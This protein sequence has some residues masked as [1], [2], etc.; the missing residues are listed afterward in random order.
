MKGEC[1]LNKNKR[2]EICLL[3]LSWK[4]K[5]YFSLKQADH[6][7][8]KLI[9]PAGIY[10]FKVNNRN[11]KARCEICSKL[12]IKTPERR[13]WRCSGFFIVNFEHISHNANG[14]VLVSLLLTLN[15]FHNL[16]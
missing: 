11:T 10:L 3:K 15:I 6:F 8:F 7:N 4:P 14:A 12:T 9:N 1:N 16:F 13:H 5:I 2:R